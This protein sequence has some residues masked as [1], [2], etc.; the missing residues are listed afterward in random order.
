MKSYDPREGKWKS[1]KPMNEGRHKLCSVVYN[2]EIY[3]IGGYGLSVERYNIRTNTWTNVGSLNRERYGSCACV[4][5]GKIYVIG[6]GYGDASKSIEAYDATNNEW[7]IETN[8]E[9]PRDDAL[10]VA[11]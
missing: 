1:L 10:V 5:N 3:A 11:L 6:G 9:T 8:M 2:D 7:K 4:V